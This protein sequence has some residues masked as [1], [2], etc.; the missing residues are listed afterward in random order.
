MNILRLLRLARLAICD[1]MFGCCCSWLLFHEWVSRVDRDWIGLELFVLGCLQ[2]II[3]DNVPW[4]GPVSP[5]DPDASFYSWEVLCFTL[6]VPVLCFQFPSSHFIFLN[7]TSS[8]AFSFSASFLFFLFL[9]FLSSSHPLF[10]L[11]SSIPSPFFF[12]LP[13]PFPL[14]LSFLCLI[15]LSFLCCVSVF[16]SLSC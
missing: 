15:S 12:P 7:S 10:S 5:D 14:S 11:F 2:R 8:S 4:K 3:T 16:S 13:F 1:W 6:C 9:L